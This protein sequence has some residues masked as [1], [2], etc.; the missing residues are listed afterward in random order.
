M[1][2]NSTT[3][4]NCIWVELTARMILG[5]TFVYTGYQKA[6]APEAFA[7]IIYGYDLFP[8]FAINLIAIILPYLELVCGT[9]LIAG[10]YPR[11]AAFILCGMLFTFMVAIGIN[12]ARGH[13]FDCG[14]FTVER[15]GHGG[16]LWL[17]LARDAIY[18]MLGLYILFFRRPRQWCLIW[19]NHTSDR[20]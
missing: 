17:L 10:I 18:L 15:F 8:H 7:Q 19:D 13:Q 12:L 14:C 5:G 1:K 20:A 11:G 4:Y 16:S 3:W 2:N 9:A 6:I